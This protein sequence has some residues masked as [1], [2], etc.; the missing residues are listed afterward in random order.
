MLFRCMMIVFLLMISV[1]P[2]WASEKDASYNSIIEFRQKY[3]QR[4]NES[5]LS[6]LIV[7]TEDWR[8]DDTY[9]VRHTITNPTNE[10]IE[11]KLTRIQVSYDTHNQKKTTSYHQ[12]VDTI[13]D[14]V[15]EPNETITVTFPLSLSANDPIE[16][17]LYGNSPIGLISTSLTLRP[18]LIF[19]SHRYSRQQT[20]L[21]S[22]LPTI[23]PIQRSQRCVISTYLLTS[24]KYPM[25]KQLV[26]ITVH[27]IHS[28]LR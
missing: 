4:L 3:Q 9:Y 17:I 22:L 25:V 1:M 12:Y 7:T 11:K 2:V 10:K 14:L 28:L 26:L 23:P 19:T 13:S 16:L 27:P 6:K 8:E 18:L 21:P 24:V 15:I 20:A 5:P